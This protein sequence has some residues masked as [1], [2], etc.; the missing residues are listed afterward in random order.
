MP[1]KTV[2]YQSFRTEN[3]PHYITRCMETVRDWAQLKGFDYR[4]I[5]DRMFSYAPA[6]YREKVNNDKCLISDLARLELAR[7]FLDGGYDRTVWVD[8]DILVF[9]P[10]EF[11]IQIQDG[12][13]LCKEV[14][15]WRKK[16]RFWPP[17]TG[18]AVNNSV[19]VFCKGNGFLDFYIDKCKSI[20]RERQDIIHVEVGTKFLTRVHKKDPIK[21]IQDVGLFSPVVMNDIATCGRTYLRAFARKFKT[22]IHAANL[23]NFFLGKRAMEIDMTERVY[24]LVVDRLLESRGDVVNRFMK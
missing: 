2:V 6:W 18:A 24:D 14:W 21:L 7:E 13:A 22:R 3:V 23:C 9:S 19:S 8:A 5:D 1:M 17:K 15:V 10:D 11:D 12:F 4:F 16:Y 20:V